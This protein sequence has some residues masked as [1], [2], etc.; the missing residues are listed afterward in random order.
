MVEWAYIFWSRSSRRDDAVK[1]LAT[2]IANMDLLSAGMGLVRVVGDEVGEG[3][4]LQLFLQRDGSVCSQDRGC[5]QCCQ[6][7]ASDSFMYLAKTY[8]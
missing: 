1:G 5:A 6:Q 4:T 7:L 2:C 3:R 8:L